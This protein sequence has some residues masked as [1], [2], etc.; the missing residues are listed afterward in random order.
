[1]GTFGYNYAIDPS[2]EDWQTK[3]MDV[4]KGMVQT[5]WEA[6]PYKRLRPY[7]GT[8]VSSIT[9]VFAIGFTPQAIAIWL[10]TSSF[11]VVN[12]DEA[13]IFVKSLSAYAK[14]GVTE[15]ESM[16]D[17]E[18]ILTPEVMNQILDFWMF[19]FMNPNDKAIRDEFE[20]LFTNMQ[21][22]PQYGAAMLH[23][24]SDQLAASVLACCLAQF[25][26]AALFH[27]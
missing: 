27:L 7:L 23:N 8:L 24:A 21:L 26:V 19:P 5:L 22:I 15:I 4:A 11:A 12:V 25:S 18:I 2:D 20:R 1:M 13:G 14:A 6:K 17:I 10:A 3:S 9:L 16:W